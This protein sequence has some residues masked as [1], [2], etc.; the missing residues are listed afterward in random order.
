MVLWP[1]CRSRQ[2]VSS[3]SCRL[4]AEVAQ[5]SH[6]I[7][8]ICTCAVNQAMKSLYSTLILSLQYAHNHPQGDL[9]APQVNWRKFLSLLLLHSSFLTFLAISQ[10]LRATLMPKQRSLALICSDHSRL[11]HRGPRLSRSA[12]WWRFR[13]RLRRRE[14]LRLCQFIFW[15]YCRISRLSMLVKLMSGW[16][17]VDMF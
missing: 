17:Q 2:W 5:S 1:A 3:G 8:T 13:E 9:K 14:R 10:L 15:L 7:S 12:R 6:I 16:R 11:R 4:W